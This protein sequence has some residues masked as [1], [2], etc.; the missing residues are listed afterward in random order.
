VALP[1]RVIPPRVTRAELEALLP[2]TLISEGQSSFTDS[3]A[4]RLLNIRTATARFHGVVVPP[5]SAFSFLQVLEQVTVATGYSLA[6]VILGSQTVLGPGGGVCQVSTTCFR[7][8]FLGGYPILERWPHSYRVGWY[9]PPLGLDAA[10]FEPTTDMRFQ[11]D[12]DS[13][14]LI[15]TETNLEAQTLHFRF[16]G[17]APGRTVRIEGPETSNPVTAGEPIIE[18]DPSLAPGQRLLVE[19][20]H[21]GIDA[22]IYRIIEQDG[23]IIS[24]EALPSHY[25]AWPARYRVGPQPQP[26]PAPEAASS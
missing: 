26:T 15:Q 12:S 9:E 10:V 23:Q 14:L 3:E 18:V 25:Q 5:Q 1:V 8:A 19:R 4:S 11:N 21:D 20:A 16:Y 24:R 7:A 22:T 13:P 2:L 17:V 6:W